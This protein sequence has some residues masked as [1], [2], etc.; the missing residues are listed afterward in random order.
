MSIFGEFWWRT[1]ARRARLPYVAL[2][3]LRVVPARARAEKGGY[4]ALAMCRTRPT[5]LV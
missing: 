5:T 4:M 2:A 3:W 1:S